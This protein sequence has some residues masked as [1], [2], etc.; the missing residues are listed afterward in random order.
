M[1]TNKLSLWLDRQKLMEMSRAKKVAVT[2]ASM[3]LSALIY[4]FFLGPWFAI[5]FV[6]LL[7]VHELGHVVAAR[8]KGYTTSAP[9]FIPLFGALVVTPNY[10]NPDEKAYI[11]YG[12]PLAGGLGGL[13][14]FMMW[15]AGG[16]KSQILLLL[17]Y[18]TTLINLS[19]LI[20]ISPFDGSRITQVIGRWFEWVCLIGLLAFAMTLQNQRG[21]TI[22]IVISAVWCY[23]MLFRNARNRNKASEILEPP[24]PIGVRLK[25]LALYCLL[26]TALTVFL[27]LQTPYLRPLIGHG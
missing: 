22:L 20:P 18:T 19:N 6:I 23:F 10:K 3:S 21:Q 11:S 17:C 27:I 15:Y 4:S 24:V 9:I 13:I 16:C 1:K 26:L 2:L 14:V 25:W 8:F 7:L 12:G 5:G